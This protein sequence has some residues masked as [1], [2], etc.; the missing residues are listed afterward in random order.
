MMTEAKCTGNALWLMAKLLGIGVHFAV[1]ILYG[2]WDRLYIRNK[3]NVSAQNICITFAHC[4]CNRVH[5][6]I[7][8]AFTLSPLP[9]PAPLPSPPPPVPVPNKQPCFCGRKAKCL[10]L[11][12]RTVRGRI[13]TGGLE[14][15]VYKNIVMV[16]SHRGPYVWRA[17]SPLLA[18][19]KKRHVWSTNFFMGLAAGLNAFTV[20][21]SCLYLERTRA[22]LVGCV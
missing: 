15:R 2:I 1:P 7:V 22:G 14:W 4:V 20:K 3:Q 8:F 5:L 13:V 21:V 6:H 9:S 10:L 11:V 12:Q 18:L 17:N 19:Q 16:V